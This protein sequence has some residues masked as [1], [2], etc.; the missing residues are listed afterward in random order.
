MTARK[1]W[2]FD[3]PPPLPKWPEPES[4]WGM[5]PDGHTSPYLHTR[6]PECGY[7]TRWKQ[8]G[9][10]RCACSPDCPPI[11]RRAREHDQ[12]LMRTDGHGG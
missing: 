11:S 10:M 2:I 8:F 3:N 6:C 7:A 4:W 5:R 1:G 12:E 9:P